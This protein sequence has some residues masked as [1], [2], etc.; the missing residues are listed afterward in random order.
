[1]QN[2][3]TAAN[4]LTAELRQRLEADYTF[5]RVVELE[6]DPVRGNF[7]AAHLKEVN[8]RIFQDLPMAWTG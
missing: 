5:K 3:P 2:K 1:M 4:A 8:W 7:D 6:L